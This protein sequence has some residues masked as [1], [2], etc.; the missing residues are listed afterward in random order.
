MSVDTQ[1]MQQV[2]ERFA[3]VLGRSATDME[4][5]AQLLSD[6]RAAL[7]AH[8]GRELPESVN[9]RFLDAQGTPTIV[10]PDLASAELSEG[11]LETVAGGLVPAL[12]G[13]GA[14]I[15]LLYDHVT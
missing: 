14:A 13:L 1:K 12:I 15:Y 5:R 8:F 10:L 4:F 7:S 9:I 2:N 3:E 6:S 11:E